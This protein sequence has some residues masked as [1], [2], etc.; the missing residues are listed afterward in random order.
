M[1][2]EV[3]DNH[4]I[5]EQLEYTTSQ[6]TRKGWKSRYDFV[7]QHIDKNHVVLDCACGLGE[8]T[9][10]I[11][12]QCSKAV[13]VDL[14]NHFIEYCKEKWPET[15]FF[16]LDVTNG[17][18]FPDDNFDVIVSIETLEHLPTMYAVRSALSTFHRIL[19]PN[20]IFI[21]TS[22]NSEITARVPLSTLIKI[23]SRRFFGNLANQQPTWHSH[24]RH[25]SS[26][27]LSKILSQYFRSISIFGKHADSI[28]K[29][30]RGASNLIALARN[31]KPG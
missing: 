18:P 16:C 9:H 10:M 26:E 31:S 2:P 6:E 20:G 14:D 29:D 11:A 22:P 13:G 30:L 25:W 28:Q 5:K 17:L 8:N 23:W 27:A 4:F 1:E 24:Y 7:L 3:V 21:A 19:K 12:Q 15:D